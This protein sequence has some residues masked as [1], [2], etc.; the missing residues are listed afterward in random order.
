MSAFRLGLPASPGPQTSTRTNS[1]PKQT[2]TLKRSSSL[3]QDLTV[4]EIGPEDEVTASFSVK[5]SKHSPG[6]A[7]ASS[8]DPLPHRS[9]E[10]WVLETVVS[11]DNSGHSVQL[12]SGSSVNV[13]Y[14]SAA[15]KAV[16]TPTAAAEKEV[17]TPTEGAA[18]S[19][20]TSRPKPPKS[21]FKKTAEAEQCRSLENIRE[22]LLPKQNDPFIE[23]IIAD[24]LIAVYENFD[25]LSVFNTS[26]SRNERIWEGRDA[27]DNVWH[28]YEE[29]DA[30]K[31]V[32]NDPS[33]L[34]IRMIDA[35]DVLMTIHAELSL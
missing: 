22:D 26:E 29:N 27:I 16:K 14:V 7:S 25:N 32:N 34:F 19:T 8:A 30:G 3:A 15:Q 24:V 33:T 23:D 35:I 11:P 17:Q 10:G 2:A 6:S 5:K 28:S 1:T 12:P 9:E 20:Q 4:Q 31:L 18:E 21:P 13:T